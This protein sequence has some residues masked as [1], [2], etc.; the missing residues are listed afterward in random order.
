MKG[1]APVGE[2]DNSHRAVVSAWFLRTCAGRPNEALVHAFADAFSVLWARTYLTLGDITLTAI[3]DR[4]LHTAAEHY[5]P[6]AC[7]AIVE[8]T[9]ELGDMANATTSHDELAEGVQF[10]LVELLT[11]LGNLTAEILT[12]TLHAVLSLQPPGSPAP[13]P[14]IRV[15]GKDDEP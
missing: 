4:V 7:L 9:L 12:P 5:P 14:R 15:G 11:I 10:V 13:R 3:V 1:E 2:D 8:S 6:L